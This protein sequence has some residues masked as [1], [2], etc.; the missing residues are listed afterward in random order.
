MKGST[1]LNGQPLEWLDALLSGD[2]KDRELVLLAAHL[3]SY[4]DSGELQMMAIALADQ[5]GWT[6]LRLA[7]V[8]HRAD[9]EGWL[10]VV[11]YREDGLYFF[12][13]GLITPQESRY[14][15]LRQTME[16]G[17]SPFDVSDFDSGDG[18]GAS[19][20]V[21]ATLQARQSWFGSSL[22]DYFEVEEQ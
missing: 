4:L 5:L 9:S 17:E 13:L 7:R 12:E 11:V 10:D 1:N 6:P 2:S 18:E 20:A 8:L 3:M 21:E 15:A 22:N 19:S 16:L 14:E